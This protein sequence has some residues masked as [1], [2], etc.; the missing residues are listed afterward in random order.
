MADEHKGIKK[1][2]HFNSA[3][4]DSCSDIQGKCSV[5]CEYLP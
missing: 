1:V 5:P 4:E 3:K 2:G